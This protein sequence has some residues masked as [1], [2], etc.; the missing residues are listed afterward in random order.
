MKKKYQ[1]STKVRRAQ[2]QAL[3]TEFKIL[4]MKEDKYVDKVFVRTLT[5]TKMEQLSLGEKILR[6]MTIGFDYM[7]TQSKNPKMFKPHDDL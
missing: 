2:L 3:R 5:T 4:S 7:F 6:S 1:G